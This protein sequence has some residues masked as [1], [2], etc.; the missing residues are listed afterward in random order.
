M[1]DSVKTRTKPSPGLPQ[2]PHDAV[3]S[4]GLRL[5][6]RSP[7]FAGC[8]QAVLLDL[9][10]FAQ[11]RTLDQGEYLCRSGAPTVRVAM[12]VDGVLEI[13]RLQPDGRR[14]LLGMALPGDFV[15]LAG[16]IDGQV[17]SH[18]I[19]ARTPGHALEF[20]VEDFLALRQ[21]HSCLVLACERLV[22]RRLRQVYE[23]MAA[24]PAWPLENRVAHMLC[25]C[26]ELFASA[27]ELPD[28]EMELGLSQSDMAD[29]LGISRQRMNYALK[30]LESEGKVRLRYGH[31]A[32][33][34]VTALQ[35]LADN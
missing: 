35:R 27:S 2:Q 17:M 7:A 15:S 12:L 29:W 10:R 9:L 4:K 3:L 32:L 6:V 24:D 26:S 21:H 31:V 16:M 28:R 34:D 30:R 20:V 33:A 23:R 13:A 22:V 19:C 1:A 25:Q 8:E 11:V 14:Y 5:L 18:D